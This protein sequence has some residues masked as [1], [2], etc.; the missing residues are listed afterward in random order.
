MICRIFLPIVGKH[1]LIILY[2]AVK[3][4]KNE[5]YDYQGA[6]RMFV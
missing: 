6:G 4:R 1:A 2:R 3:I 5:V